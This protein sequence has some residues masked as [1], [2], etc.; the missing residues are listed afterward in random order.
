M[1][2]TLDIG[3]KASAEFDEDLEK[4][5]SERYDDLLPGFAEFIVDTAYG[6]IYSRKGLALKQRFLCT[7]AVL[8]SQGGHTAPQLRI[9]M[10]NALKAGVTREEIAEVIMQI[11]L[12]GGL[13]A[14]I[15]AL[16][17]AKAL[18]SELGALS[19]EHASEQEAS[20]ET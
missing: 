9:N 12:Y 13:P 4:V 18:F 17:T 11:S 19:S 6:K 20:V 10:K 14:T 1:E 7:I 16:N 5:L 15:S 3:R 8:A 2:S